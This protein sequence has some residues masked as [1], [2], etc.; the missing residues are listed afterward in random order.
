M[1]ILKFIFDVILW[2]ISWIL[3]PFASVGTFLVLL[4]KNKA[5]GYFKTSATNKDMYA[6]QEYKSL[7]NAILIKKGK[8]KFG[9]V[10]ETMSSVLGKIERN[11]TI[12]IV[13]W[14]I[15]YWFGKSFTYRH[16]KFIVT[17]Y[18]LVGIF[19]NRVLWVIERNHC[20]LSINDLFE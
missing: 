1:F 12:K 7:W 18:T 3:E 14:K 9:N 15:P 10:L 20:I 13:T 17:Q 2:I 19:L 5:K 16:R 11:S 8:Y 4:F 6:N